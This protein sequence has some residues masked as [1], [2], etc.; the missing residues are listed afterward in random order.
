M[1]MSHVILV[2]ITGTLLL[3]ATLSFFSIRNNINGVLTK[4]FPSIQLANDISEDLEIH[5]SALIA[6]SARNFP[7][8]ED[9]SR[10]SL[11]RL[12]SNIRQL[13]PTLEESDEQAA[14][15]NLVTE[16]EVYKSRAANLV[17]ASQLSLQPGFTD[18]VRKDLFPML[19]SMKQYTHQIASLN[20]TAVENENDRARDA[21]SRFSMIG[22]AA[23]VFAL[24]AAILLALHIT[25]AALTP[26]A[27]IAK[28]ASKLGSGDL[29]AKLELP[30]RDEIGELADSFNEMA[31][32]LA[33]LKGQAARR[34]ERAQRLSDAA[35]NSLYDPVIVVDSKQRI[36]NL[37]AAGI[38]IFGAVPTSPRVSVFDH[39][40]DH[41]IVR[42]IDDAVDEGRVSASEDDTGFTKLTANGFERTYRIRATPMRSEDNELLGAVAVLEDVTH[43]REVD[44]MKTEFI[45]VA[46]HELRTPVAS[47][48][49]ATDLLME[50]AVGDLNDAQKEMVEVQREDLYRLEK[51]T[52]DLLDVTRL[53]KGTMK[54]S[55]EVIPVKKMVEMVQRE[56]AGSAETNGV[57][58]KSSADP[59]VGNVWVDRL[60]IERVLLNLASNGIR[61]TPKGGTVEIWASRDK[62][63]VSFQVSDTGEGIPADY[64]ER[65]FER[66]VQVPGATQGG[67]G[68]GL[69]IAQKIVKNHGGDMKVQSELGKG[70]VFTFTLPAET[71]LEAASSPGLYVDG[72]STALG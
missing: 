4:N 64:L 43:L 11:V 46:A 42:A 55:L 36:V 48:L 63:Q 27:I 17:A 9:Q 56:L 72:T 50:G 66:F 47:L 54:M 24:G 28:H 65:I 14:G 5:R 37:N 39:I 67:A 18:S 35:I 10:V 15:Q 60:Q 38:Q 29:S 51:L 21:A 32:R 2:V 6:F 44:A 33:S 70:S 3:G 7:E 19:D 71:A 34:L 40:S 52:R 1:L 58:L 13:L 8:A 30:R 26:L 68:L 69:S 59:D 49:L 61:H 41:R 31:T 45:G 12:E 16:F 22:I 20:R 62:N 23:T 25:R 53:E 57:S